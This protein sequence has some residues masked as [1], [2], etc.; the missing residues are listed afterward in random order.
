MAKRHRYYTGIVVYTTRESVE[1]HFENQSKRLS[2]IRVLLDHGISIIKGTLYVDS[3]R[4]PTTSVAA[5]AKV[6]RR[7]VLRVVEE[8]QA[9]PYLRF[10]FERM[11]VEPT[12]MEI[13]RFSEAGIVEV[14]VENARASGIIAAVTGLIAKYGISIKYLVAQSSE[15]TPSPTL[16]FQPEK[17][18]PKALYDE[19]EKIEGILEINV[20]RKIGSGMS[21]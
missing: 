9:D 15:L 19:L 6:D 11:R 14:I 18:L 4:I 10:F 2:V 12:P 1:K 20:Y 17:R 8:V 3:L 13:G 21:V 16:I 5:V 7:L